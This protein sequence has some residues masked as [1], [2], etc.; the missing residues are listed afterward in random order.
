MT[1]I[2]V[3]KRKATYKWFWVISNMLSKNSY[4]S[5]ELKNRAVLS[6]QDIACIDMWSIIMYYNCF[7]W[8]LMKTNG[9]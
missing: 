9:Y 8:N 4:T 5:K 2:K 7:K 6:F 1:R 3:F